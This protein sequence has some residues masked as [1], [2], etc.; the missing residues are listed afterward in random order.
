MSKS[1]SLNIKKFEASKLA[2]YL[3]N[4]LNQEILRIIKKYLL[5]CC[6][7]LYLYEYNEEN[8]NYKFVKLNEKIKIIKSFR[9]CH[10]ILFLTT[11][12]QVFGFSNCVGD[13]GLQN[14]LCENKLCKISFYDKMNSKIKTISEGYGRHIMVV[15]QNNNVY[16]Q[17]YINPLEEY[18]E[19][20]KVNMKIKIII[21][22]VKT[23]FYHGLV[24]S[25]KKKVYS[26]G[27]NDY[28]QLGNVKKKEFVKCSQMKI[29]KLP[30]LCLS[31]V[32]IIEIN[33]SFDSSYVLTSQNKVYSFGDN[34]YGQLGIGDLND[35]FIPT[36][37]LFFE[38]KKIKIVKIKTGFNHCIFVDNRFNNFVCG[39][40][41][42]GQLNQ[43][44][45]KIQ[46]PKILLFGKYKFNKN[47]TK[48]INFKLFTGFNRTNI[49]EKNGNLIVFGYNHFNQCFVNTNMEDIK[50]PL[51]VKKQNFEK[52]LK[53]KK[54]K[55]I[56]MLNS[57]SFILC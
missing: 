47:E 27:Y 2:I 35:K 26:Y 31:D 4:N 51:I 20:T 23:G 7:D 53:N 3:I 46:I 22:S 1:S 43:K 36:L 39:D 30:N 33:C 37:V 15:T 45:E 17:G 10:T 19:P 29:I 48:K 50:K 41:G 32:I 18:N 52:D 56:I 5:N 12:N 14:F 6:Y 42:Y 24:L 49:L 54:I 57:H 44:N 16:I 34:F 28:G 8:E 21:M 55:E 13:S 9:S 11:K 38:N 25:D 40:N